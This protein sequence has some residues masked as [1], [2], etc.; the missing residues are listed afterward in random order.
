MPRASIA[1]TARTQ[2]LRK[3]ELGTLVP[4]TALHEGAKEK[5]EDGEC[6]SVLNVFLQQ[7]VVLSLQRRLL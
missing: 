3:Q 7:R 6:L 1:T 2:S 4:L 5:A